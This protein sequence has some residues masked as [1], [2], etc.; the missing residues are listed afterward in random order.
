[1][2]ART[3]L[4]S[5]ITGTVYAVCPVTNTVTIS[6]QDPKSGDVSYRILKTSFIQDITVIDKP[7]AGS[8]DKSAGPDASSGKIT[9]TN[10]TPAIGHVNVS[11]LSRRENSSVE[12]AKHARSLIGVGVSAEGQFVFDTIRKT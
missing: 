4:D 12:A 1:M 6:E 11:Q 10:A 8:S 3:L 7:K 2:R 5:V 9:F